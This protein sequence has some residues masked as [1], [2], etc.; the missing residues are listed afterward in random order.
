MKKVTEE[1]YKA[2]Q[3]IELFKKFSGVKYVP[4]LVKN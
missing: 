4:G 2:L 1:P 3:M